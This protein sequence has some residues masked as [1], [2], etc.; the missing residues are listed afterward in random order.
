MTNP[1]EKALNFGLERFISRMKNVR[2]LQAIAL[3]L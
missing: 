1:P 3:Y 2:T